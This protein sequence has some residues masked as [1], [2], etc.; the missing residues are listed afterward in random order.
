MAQS[1]TIAFARS[2]RCIVAI[3]AG[4]P[5]SDEDLSAYVAFCLSESFDVTWTVV[6]PRCPGLNTKQRATLVKGWE[7]RGV[8]PRTSIVTSSTLHRGVIT[9]LNWFLTGTIRAFA[10]SDWAASLEYLEIRGAMDQQQVLR[11]GGEL[12]Q[13]LGVREDFPFLVR[14][15]GAVTV[16]NP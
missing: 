9:A 6:H 7:R 10:P 2:G 12:A 5:P 4:V 3:H 8:S 15:V 13:G 16:R 14:P 1:K 11:I